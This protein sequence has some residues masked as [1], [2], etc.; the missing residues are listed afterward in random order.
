MFT[1]TAGG[2]GERGERGSRDA[3]KGDRSNVAVR[4][5]EGRIVAW[6]ERRKEFRSVS[7][8]AQFRNEETGR[9]Q[10]RYDPPE[11]FPTLRAWFLA[12]AQRR[13]GVR[14]AG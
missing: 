7:V 1:I 13:Y 14:L 3:W 9:T 4:D 11:G 10:V 12:E 8:R 5:A 6:Y 2:T